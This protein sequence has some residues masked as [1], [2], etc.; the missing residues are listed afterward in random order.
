MKRTGSKGPVGGFAE[1]S[2]V[3]VGKRERGIKK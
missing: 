1:V 3:V 2:K